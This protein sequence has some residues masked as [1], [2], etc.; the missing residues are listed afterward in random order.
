MAT[1][2]NLDSLVVGQNGRA[3]F[4]GLSSGID[5]K[6]AVDALIQAKRI[7]IDRMGQRIADRELKIAALRDVG[8]L[9]LALRDAVARLRGAVS[10]DGAGDVFK[11]KQ[12]FAT[13]TRTDTQSPSQAGQLLGISVTNAAQAATHTIEILQVATA[14]K[15]AS[16][17]IAGALGDAL[18]LAGSFEINGRAIAVDPNNSLLELRDRINAANS[19]ELATGVTASIV[20]ITASEQVL[21]LTADET[22]TDAQ[23]GAA[24]TAGGVLQSLGVLDGA[25]D[26]ANELQVAQNAQIKVDGLAT[27]IE[28]QSNTV[29]DVF[30]GVTLS[31]F[32]AEPGT[33]VRLDVER[34]LGQ[35]KQ[36]IVDFVGAYNELRT[37]LNQQ[38]MT[39][40]P[41]GDES[42]AAILAGTRAL[43]DVRARLAAAIGGAVQGGDPVFS[44]LAQIGITFQGAGQTGNPL[45]TN[46]LKIDEA[47][48][49]EALLNQTEAVR[50]LFAFGLSSSSANVVLVGFD[51]KTGYSAG[52]YQLNVAWAGGQI[53]SANIG[54]SADGSDDGTVAVQGQVLTVLQGG[55]QGLKVLYTGNASASGIQ[56]DVS[57]GLGAQLHAAM[58]AMASDRNGLVTSEIASL[59][60]QNQL[61]R[62]R[63]ERLEERLELERERLFERFVAMEA[64]LATMNQLMESLRQQI[65]SSF[66]SKQR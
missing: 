2:L 51:G 9:A 39:D 47:R 29:G 38:S 15:V 35:V 66:Y 1:Q 4:N 12:I 19:G 52:G 55:A 42:G 58:D 16:A 5:I 32:K 31:L 54:G 37:F 41:A 8:T 13:S 49:D 21:V 7:P 62:Q 63:I 36:A 44:V 28:R 3:F 10:F 60:G 30:A 57:V 25:G 22:G 18:G 11:A 23:I 6:G 43:S 48:L 34:D 14:H 65:E 33:T 53:V 45:T 20:S 24:D 17:S 64:A 50:E 40:V 56:L 46:T 61:H 26:F 59:D 27:T